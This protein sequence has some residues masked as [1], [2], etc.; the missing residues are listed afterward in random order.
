V[1]IVAVVLGRQRPNI[2]PAR[3]VLE[4]NVQPW[5]LGVV[6]EAAA[7]G[8]ALAGFLAAGQAA[9]AWA[10]QAVDVVEVA[11]GVVLSSEQRRSEC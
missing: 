7:V 3:R 8:V 1:Q 2:I 9:A 10:A 6:Q 4:G 11:V 5:A